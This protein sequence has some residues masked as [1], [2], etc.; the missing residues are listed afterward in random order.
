MTASRPVAVLGIYLRNS[1]TAVRWSKNQDRSMNSA[2]L[3]GMS[4]KAGR[5]SAGDAC[6]EA[7]V[8][9]VKSGKIDIPKDLGSG[10]M[11]AVSP[12]PISLKWAQ[13]DGKSFTTPAALDT[14][15]YLDS[16]LMEISAVGESIDQLSLERRFESKSPVSAAGLDRSV[17]PLIGNGRQQYRME[18]TGNNLDPKS[19]RIADFPDGARMAAVQSW[20]DGIPQDKRAAELLRKW[21]WRASFFFNRNSPMVDHWK[22]FEDLGMEVASHSWSHPFYPMQSPQRCRDESVMMRLFLE[23]KVGHPVISFAY[24][25][26]YGAAYDSRGDYVLRSQR[27]AGYLSGRS[28]LNGPLALDNLGEPLA[29]TTDAHFLAGRERIQ[30]AW[31]RAAATPRGVFYI[32]GHTYEIVSDADWAGFEDLLKTYGRKPATW[33]ASQGDLM[34]WKQLRETTKLTVSGDTNRLQIQLDCADLHPW[35]AARVPL[36]IKASGQLTGATANHLELP[37][38][39]GDIQFKLL[40]A[41]GSR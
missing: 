7:M 3:L 38:I 1:A 35:W 12:R 20:D 8:A 28:T 31:N 41:A 17:I 6:M 4:I 22:E 14:T 39:N 26:N 15:A 19:V 27:E 23:S 33:Y 30:A 34:V 18:I 25:F 13:T 9:P 16:D 5:P 21:G 37:L 32:W 24:P 11:R 29:M 40:P 36:A 2:P 10:L